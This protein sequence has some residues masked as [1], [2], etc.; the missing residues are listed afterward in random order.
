MVVDDETEPL[1]MQD[2]GIQDSMLH[3]N[4][5]NSTGMPAIYDILN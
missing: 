5:G 2:L 3:M 1:G 4:I